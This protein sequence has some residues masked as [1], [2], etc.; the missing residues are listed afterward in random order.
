MAPVSDKASQLIVAKVTIAGV[1][2]AALV[3]TGATTSC[4]RWG[5]YQ[6]CKSHLGSL[7][8]SSTMVVGV[9]NVPIEVKGLSKPLTLQWDNVEGQCQ[10]MVL[11]TLTDVDVILGMDV[12]SEFN[13]KIDSRKQVA[14][15]ARELHTSLML[16]K[17]VKIPAGKSRVFLVNNTLL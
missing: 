14:S 5:W 11:T 10:L 15:P 1:K 4:C 7:K 13:V 6:K 17:N 16:D 12:L 2:V 8:Q 9:G 3:D